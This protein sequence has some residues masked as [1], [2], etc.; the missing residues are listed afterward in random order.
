MSRARAAAAA[1]PAL[2]AA[3]SITLARDASW[4]YAIIILNA[5]LFRWAEVLNAGGFSA[6]GP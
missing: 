6:I 3:S 2:N 4:I 5:R 1:S